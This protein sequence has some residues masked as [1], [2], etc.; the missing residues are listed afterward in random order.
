MIQTKTSADLDAC[1]GI[2]MEPNA[3]IRMHFIPIFFHFGHWRTDL[4]DK[5]GE[6]DPYIILCFKWF[7]ENFLTHIFDIF[8]NLLHGVRQID[9]HVEIDGEGFWFSYGK[10]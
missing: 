6:S 8:K 10:V 5:L 4:V 3:S 7:G 2:L 1:L 9:C